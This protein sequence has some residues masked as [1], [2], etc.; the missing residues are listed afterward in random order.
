[1]KCSLFT[2]R[3]LFCCGAAAG[4]WLVWFDFILIVRGIPYP[5]PDHRNCRKSDCRRMVGRGQRSRPPW[6]ILAVTGHPVEFPAMCQAN[7]DGARPRTTRAV[8]EGPWP[9]S[10]SPERVY[11]NSLAHVLGAIGEPTF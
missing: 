8:M 1:L 11:N 5:G 7:L 4:A 10:G 2:L 9:A 6:P 3:R